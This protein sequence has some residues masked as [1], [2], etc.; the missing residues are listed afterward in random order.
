MSQRATRRCDPIQVRSASTVTALGMSLDPQ[1]NMFKLSARTIIA[2]AVVVIG[3][4]AILVALARQFTEN[5]KSAGGLTAYLDVMPAAIVKGYQ[6]MYGGTSDGPHE[7][8]I[9]AAIS[10]TASATLVSNATVL[11]KVS[12]LGLLG[13]EA[14]LEP[15]KIAD[16][17]AYGAFVYLPSVDVYTIRL[18]IH[19][20]GSQQPVILDFN[21]DH[22]L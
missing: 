11:A 12:G 13:H 8:H 6:T 7:Y 2:A 3:I 1:V 22:R 4:V 10:D 15:M 16:T 9:V 20:P 18:T 14:N 21:Y 5:E 19:R 17:T